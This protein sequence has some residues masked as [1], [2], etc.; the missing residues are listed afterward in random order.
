[1]MRDSPKE[2]EKIGL[3]EMLRL[4]NEK[5]KKKSLQTKSPNNSEHPK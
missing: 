2:I 3:Q 5:S 4:I 1:M